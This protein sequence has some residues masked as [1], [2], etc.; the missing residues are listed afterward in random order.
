MFPKILAASCLALLA[1]GCSKKS[2]DDVPVIAELPEFS[3]VDQDEHAFNRESMEGDIWMT[4]F[5]FTH[6]RATCPRLTAQMK[7]LQ[8]RLSDVPRA[9]FL[10]VSVDPRNDTPEVIKAYMTTNGID[11]ANWRFV[12]G[13]EEAI[14]DF[15]VGGFKTGYGRTKWAPELTHSN[16]FALVDER[17]RIRG[18]YGSDDEGI[19]DLERDLRALAA[20]IPASR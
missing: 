3:L 18:Y 8:G 2:A 12:T 16:S 10:S 7:K 15:V 4:A 1:L 17:A 20:A 6:C 9:H 14:Q 19:A 13:R 5:V 11:E